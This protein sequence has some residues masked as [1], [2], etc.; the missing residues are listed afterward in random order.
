M[1]LSKRV[2]LIVLIVIFIIALAV[3]FSIYLGQAREKNALGERI[4]DAQTLLPG[5]INEREELEDQLTQAESLLTRSQ[6]EFPEAV[7]SIQY[8]DDLF[9]I[10]DDCNVKI[11]GLTS[12]KPTTEKLGAVTY[13]ISRYTVVITGGVEA[14]LDFIYAIRTGNDFQLPWSAD[15]TAISVSESGATISLTIYAYKG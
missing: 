14:I 2:W 6:A 5:L 12:S 3:L 7:D 11:T 4:S 8:D 13:S 15:V 10:A 1:S 9:E